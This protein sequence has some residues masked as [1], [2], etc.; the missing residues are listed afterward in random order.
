MN[1]GYVDLIDTFSQNFLTCTTAVM[2]IEYTGC[3][4]YNAELRKI[5]LYFIGAR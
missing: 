4:K 2:Y 5:V 1:N 3:E